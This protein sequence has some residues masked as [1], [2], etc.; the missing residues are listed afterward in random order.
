VE[1]LQSYLKE[2]LKK[3]FSPQTF[4]KSLSSSSIKRQSIEKQEKKKHRKKRKEEK[5]QKFLSF[6]K[7]EFNIFRGENIFKTFPCESI[8]SPSILPLQKLFSK[9][10]ENS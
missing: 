8:F 5:L 1:P 10:F 3:L 2:S 4:Q 6:D 7:G 9:S